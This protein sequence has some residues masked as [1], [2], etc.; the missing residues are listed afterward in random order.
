[1]RTRLCRGWLECV[2]AGLWLSVSACA[3]QH[4]Q[5]LRLAEELG[6]ARAEAT[7]HAA[8]AAQLESRLSRLEQRI[9][10]SPPNRTAD[11]AELE[12]RLDR[13]I[14]LNARTA[15]EPPSPPATAGAQATCA[16]DTQ[17]PPEA[18]IRVL[19]ERLRGRP[20]RL[21]GPLT[22]DQNETLRKLLKPERQLD[23]DNPWPEAWY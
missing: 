13:L 19:V 2:A 6:R 21:K 9:A 7:W 1:V 11:D 23:R 22:R 3:G 20:D 15:L 10:E 4:D 5:E 18:Q 17:S 12:K 14:A 16:S 8:R